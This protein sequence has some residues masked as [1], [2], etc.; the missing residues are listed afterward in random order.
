MTTFSIVFF[1]FEIMS[2]Q[3]QEYL[4]NYKNLL[5]KGYNL[6]IKPYNP[7]VPI[8]RNRRPTPEQVKLRVMNSQRLNKYLDDVSE[9]KDDR[10]KKVFEVLQILSEIAFDRKVIVLRTLGSVIGKLMNQLYTAVLVNETSLTNLKASFGKQQ[11]IYLPS[12]RS[13]ADFML[14]SFICFSYNMEVPAIAAG[15][16][17]HGMMGLGEMLRKTGAFFMRR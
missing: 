9:S 13:Y 10:Q 11:V 5:D 16:D 12:H 17:F 14:M 8:I 2:K 3:S 6:M 4:T 15:M 1:Q 7:V